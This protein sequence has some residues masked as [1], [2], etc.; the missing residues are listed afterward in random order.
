[1]RGGW[2][3]GVVTTGLVALLATSVTAAPQLAIDPAGYQLVSKTRINRV[4]FAYTYRATVVNTG[5]DAWDVTGTVGSA[6]AGL[7]ITDNALTFGP[8]PAGG[9]VLSADT[10]T[11]RQN[12]TG[13]VTASAFNWSFASG[14]PF[15]LQLGASHV[16]AFREG[17]FALRVEVARANGFTAPVTVELETPPPGFAAMPVILEGELT[18]AMLPVA[19]SAEVPTG[20]L[21][22]AVRA[23]AGNISTGTESLSVTVQPPAPRSQELIRAALAAGT[24][25]HG[26]SLLYRAYAAFGDPRLPAQFAGSGSEPEDPYLVPDIEAA[27]GSVS[28]SLHAELLP[29]ILRPGEPESWFN[30]TESGATTAT[31]TSEV[32]RLSAVAQAGTGLVVLPE[33]C[34]ERIA[35]R[36]WVSRRSIQYPIRVWVRCLDTSEAETRIN[37]AIIDKVLASAERLWPG[38]TG[39]MGHPY[40][41]NQPGEQYTRLDIGD[42]AIDVYVVFNRGPYRN[43]FQLA[44]G[45]SGGSAIAVAPVPENVAP[46]RASGYVLLPLMMVGNEGLLQATLAHELMHVLQYAHNTPLRHWYREASAHWA[47]V[48]F[49]RTLPPASGRVSWFFAYRHFAFGF[50]VKELPLNVMNGYAEY[51]AFI[52][53]YFTE[54]TVGPSVIADSWAALGTTDDPNDADAMLD[55]VSGFEANFRDFTR[56]NVNIPLDPSALP[57]TDRYTALDPEEFPDDLPPVYALNVINVSSTEHSFVKN[58]PPLMA[59]YW[60]FE[61]PDPQ[62]E[63]I[64]FDLKSVTGLSGIDIDALVKTDDGQWKRHDWNGEERVTFC[65]DKP[66]ERVEELWLVIGNHLV[67]AKGGEDMGVGFEVT[68]SAAPCRPV[69]VGKSTF[70]Y[71]DSLSVTWEA[72]ADVVWE[73]IAREPSEE[74]EHQDFYP[75]G[76]VT[77]VKLTDPFCGPLVMSNESHSLGSN[78]GLM[79]VYF[80]ETPPTAVAAGGEQWPGTVTYNCPGGEPFSLPAEALTTGDWLETGGF[81][82]LQITV[83]PQTNATSTAFK[84]NWVSSDGLRSSSWDFKLEI[85]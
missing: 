33:M 28:P 49:D 65:F 21:V 69:W 9:R 12:R 58:V 60:K 5:T 10:F 51:T 53:P 48:H 73:K 85:R 39:L 55:A 7:T 61:F 19:I 45:S 71:Q 37:A 47:A 59:R 14:P 78:S 67:P 41:D 30:T 46:R 29:F 3:G 57:A 20:D 40:L 38:L 62:T 2:I 26:T 17:E 83:D 68:V 50:Q 81:H 79:E 54:Q 16:D 4:T 66:E 27:L 32:S 35:N 80:A 42:D 11:V 31:F 56:R 64:I 23:V 36:P 8:V 22:L 6:A 84:G 18:D 76:T 44:V 75:T 25:D 82:P 1:M 63:K 77:M 43:G 13:K 70:K 15:S 24:L 74:E 34:S 52:W 72:S